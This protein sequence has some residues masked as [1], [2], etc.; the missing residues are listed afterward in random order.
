MKRNA[1]M[2]RRPT[3]CNLNVQYNL[4][5]KRVSIAHKMIV[6]AYRVTALESVRATYET[7]I[8]AS[9]FQNQ[10]NVPQCKGPSTISPVLVLGYRLLVV[11]HPCCQVGIRVCLNVP[12]APPDVNDQALL[13]A[14]WL[15]QT[16]SSM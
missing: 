7:Q 2:I 13:E 8:A 15:V 10:P 3:I 1:I 4:G 9:A 6:V 12:K 14:K 5:R 11:V 16:H